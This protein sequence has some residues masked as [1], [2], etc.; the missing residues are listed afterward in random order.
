[1]PFT[2]TNRNGKTV[3]TTFDIIDF[4]AY[5][6]ENPNL[7]WSVPPASESP[8]VAKHFGMDYQNQAN[9]RESQEYKDAVGKY[10]QENGLDPSIFDIKDPQE[11]R[12]SI[13]ITK[14]NKASIGEK[15]VM[16]LEGSVHDEDK[17]HTSA[18]WVHENL[19]K[20]LDMAKS[21][22]HA[23]SQRPEKPAPKASASGPTKAQISKELEE[24]E[25]ALAAAQAEIERLTGKQA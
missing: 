13:G 16:F 3:T 21:N 14:D 18:D 2:F 25:A 5:R 10:A 12:G 19:D 23:P 8:S 15:V 17:G 1:M 7:T 6:A 4:L 9:L 24:K 11:K 22:G 20:I